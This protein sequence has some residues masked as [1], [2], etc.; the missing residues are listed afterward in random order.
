MIYFRRQKE[1]YS[2]RNEIGSECRARKNSRRHGELV[3][4]GICRALVSE[5]NA[6]GERLAWYAQH[7]EMV[8]VNSTFYSVPDARMI[9]RWCHSTP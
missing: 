4:P 5:E 6:G 1:S 9:E 7:F 3:G 2:F 8:E